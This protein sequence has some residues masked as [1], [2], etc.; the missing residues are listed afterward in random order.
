M[1]KKKALIRQ[2]AAVE[3]LGSVTVICSDKTGTLTQN[4]M[5]VTEV[6]LP[7]RRFTLAEVVAGHRWPMRCAFGNS[8]NRCFPIPGSAILCF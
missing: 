7:N 1:L 3:T 2:L 8:I 5:T 4:K 6:V